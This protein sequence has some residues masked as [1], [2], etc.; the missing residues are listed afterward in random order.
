MILQQFDFDI[1][2]MYLRHFFYWKGMSSMIKKFV[3]TCDL[4]QGVKAV[5]YK[6]EVEYQLVESSEPGDLA[7]VDFYASLPRSLGGIE[8]IFVMLDT[9][10]KYVKL[11]AIKKETTRT[12][13]SV[14]FDKY[15]PEMEEPKRLL[16]D[17]GTQFKSPVR[18][19][20]LRRVGIWPVH[21]S[22]RH[23]QSNPK[24]E[25]MRESVHLFRTHC[26][27]AHTRWAKHLREIEYFMNITTHSST[28]FSPQELH[29]GFKPH[30]QI[31][32][33]GFHSKLD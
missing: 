29:F 31:R 17:N 18:G 14:L 32:E 11:Y 15:V 4:C 19:E 26:S 1:T 25:V 23:P 22:I 20:A 28:G 16:T 2:L 6:A 24:E 33:F 7:T 21:C 30:D 8:Y 3:V 12:A 5:N 13:L 10:S 9:C 27:D